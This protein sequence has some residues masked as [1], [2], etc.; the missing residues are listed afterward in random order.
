MDRLELSQQ[1]LG[2]VFNFRRGC[3]HAAHSFCLEAKGPSL[4]L[5]KQLLGFLVL[6][7][8]NPG[9]ALKGVNGPAYYS[10]V[11]VTT[12]ICF[13]QLALK[14]IKQVVKSFCG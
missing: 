9:L 14:G 10:T 13:I 1:N 3:V 5:P 7:I 6:E 11:Q 2:R 4:E 8:V 12:L